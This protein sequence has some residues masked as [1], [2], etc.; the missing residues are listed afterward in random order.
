V[1]PIKD[2]FGA[3]FF[4]SVGMMVQPDIIAQY[5]GS[6]LILSCTVIVGMIVFGSFGMIVTGQTLKVAIQSGFSLTQIGEFAFIIATLGMSLGVLEA[7]IYPIVVAVSVL[8]TFTTP[9]FIKLSTPFYEFVERHLPQNLRFLIDRYQSEASKEQAH[10]NIWT[11]A[12]RRYGWRTLIYSIVLV[13]VSI[14]STT[15]LLPALANIMPEWYNMVTMLI[16]LG[17]MSPFLLAMLLPFARLLMLRS[18]TKQPPLDIAVISI[19]I[20]N[21]VI[22]LYFVSN[23]I[24]H[25]YSMRWGVAIAIALLLLVMLLFSRRIRKQ[26][27]NIENRFMHNLHERDLRRSGKNTN[28]VNDLHLAYINVGSG[29]EFIGER[30]KNSNVRSKYGVNIVSIQRAQRHISV[31]GGEARI[32]PGDIIG[33]VGTD[34]QIA[35]LLP[36]VEKE[37]EIDPTETNPHIKLTGIMLTDRSILVGKCPRNSHLL[38]YYDALL[39]AVQRNDEYLDHNPDTVFAVGDILYLV[40]DES[41]LSTLK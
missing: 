33:V 40:G 4:I 39:L 12:L 34:E 11:N 17:V 26:M 14:I 19:S 1:T 25:A 41:I 35:A 28:L 31:P 23:V 16:T 13:A 2:L 18:S 32:F 36:I 27:T 37:C 30:L 21:F 8:T 20:L 38:D 29:C 7:N 10:D 22:S 15:Y 9:Y 3:V 24:A 6:I 5:W